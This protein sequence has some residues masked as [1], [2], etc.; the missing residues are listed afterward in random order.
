MYKSHLSYP[1][2]SLT[3]MSTKRLDYIDIAKGIGIL[4]VIC[5]HSRCSG[6]MWFGWE[7]C[8]PVFFV[9][10]GYTYR[11]KDISLGEMIKTKAHRLLIPF[12]F[13]NF[14]FIA[15]LAILR[16]LS[17]S[18]LLGP[19]YSRFCIY[20]EGHP[21]YIEL[22]HR[23]CAPTWFLTALFISYI[24]IYFTKGEKRKEIICIPMF[25]IITYLFLPLPILLPW[26]IDTSFYF[27]AFILI[28]KTIREYDI[29]HKGWWLMAL[30]AVI[31]YFIMLHDGDINHSLRILGNDPSF[32]FIASVL[33]SILII[34]ISSL[35]E[36]TL[37]C[38]PLSNLG[39][40][41]L[42]IF[43]FHY[44]FISA[45]NQLIERHY[46]VYDSLSFYIAG[47]C[48]IIITAYICYYLSLMTS[49]LL[50]FLR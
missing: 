34:W 46:S 13:T 7:F 32:T 22:Y 24:W 48:S 30:F 6:L 16:K 35:T 3:A 42:L 38:K 45:F 26:S 9:L 10:S 43:C 23:W 39:K 37:L 21:L 49:K 19:I 5:S 40:N 33:G 29:I 28:G 1:Q 18:H 27:A 2:I 15:I 8:I 11:Y 17:L 36:K 47:L 4:F 14:V 44:P 20:P 50:P 12:F 31:Y 25:L 41:S